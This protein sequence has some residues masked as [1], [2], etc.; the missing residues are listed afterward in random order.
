MERWFRVMLLLRSNADDSIGPVTALVVVAT[1][2][3]ICVTPTFLA[4]KKQRLEP[5]IATNSFLD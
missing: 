1:G 5:V 4:V 3:L 2:F